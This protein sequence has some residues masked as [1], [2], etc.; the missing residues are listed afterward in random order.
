[1]DPGITPRAAEVAPERTVRC[2][3][4][5][6]CVAD[7]VDGAV[8]EISSNRDVV[9]EGEPDVVEPDGLVNGCGD[10]ARPPRFQS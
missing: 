3:L 10:A 1:M 2:F 4:L 9:A 7:L 6:E 8:Q 5:V